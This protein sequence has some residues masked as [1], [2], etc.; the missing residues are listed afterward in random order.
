MYSLVFNV[1]DIMHF[2]IDWLDSLYE[3]IKIDLLIATSL[4]PSDDGYQLLVSGIEAIMTQKPIQAE[5][6]DIALILAIQ[7]VE[8]FS[9]VPVFALVQILFQQFHLDVTS[10]L[11]FEVVSH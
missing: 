2:Y 11:A 5:E 7:E 8:G 3:F 6:V 1:L 9:G 4:N 10:D